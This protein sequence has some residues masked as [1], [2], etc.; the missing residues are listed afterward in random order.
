[1]HSEQPVNPGTTKLI[2]EVLADP[3]Q[4]GDIG[5]LMAC[6]GA[7]KT[8]CLTH[9]ALDR[10]LQGQPVLH[11]CIDVL[12]DRTKLWYQEV[13]GNLLAGKDAESIA[14]TQHRI[15]PL[16]FILAYLNQTFSPGKL[17]QSVKNLKEQAG[18]NPSL[19]VLDG[20]DF[21]NSDRRTL[22]DLKEFARQHDV[23]IWMSARTHR[24]ITQANERGI[25]YPCDAN[26]E[27]FQSILLLEPGTDAIRIKILKQGSRYETRYPEV[28]LD[29]RTHLLQRG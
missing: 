6:A 18:F 20:F 9:I 1:M 19:V 28:V 17:E 22:E 8:A 24:H 23:P 26:D 15:E 5:V 10:L 16:R 27:L 2:D 4:P 13:L 25:P 29:P 12:P 11:V 21:E 3:L 7:G 14:Q